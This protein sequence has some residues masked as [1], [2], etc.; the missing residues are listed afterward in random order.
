MKKFLFLTA[1]IGGLIVGG[2]GGGAAPP[3]GE[4]EGGAEDG[5]GTVSADGQRLVDSI[6]GVEVEVGGPHLGL[7]A[8][9]LEDLLL[10]YEEAS[11]ATYSGE[12]EFQMCAPSHA[13]TMTEGDLAARADGR[14]LTLDDDPTVS[15]MEQKTDGV[16]AIV[17]TV[18]GRRYIIAF[19]EEFTATTT[20]PLGS[21]PRT[22]SSKKFMSLN[23]VYEEERW[24]T[25]CKR[26]YKP[27]GEAKRR[28][29]SPDAF[30]RVRGDPSWRFKPGV[31]SYN[32]LGVALNYEQ[33]LNSERP[34]RDYYQMCFP[35][36]IEALSETD[37]RNMDL[38]R[39]APRGNLEMTREYRVKSAGIMEFKEGGVRKALIA[40]KMD[41]VPKDIP[42]LST[43]IYV[44]ALAPDQAWWL[45]CNEWEFSRTGAPA[46]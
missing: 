14:K 2:C 37:R 3:G 24:W 41:I 30:E 15:W 33:M 4:A 23:V 1:L 31:G 45:S 9:S 8:E 6:R 29:A 28:T 35:S 25:V 43:Y 16:V 27:E 36:H 39:F 7:G 18:P 40:L 42:K 34:G 5:D 11:T 13:G 46:R 10:R 38:N 20:F 19:R 22:V 21:E 32:P 12:H 26:S 44:K 17:G